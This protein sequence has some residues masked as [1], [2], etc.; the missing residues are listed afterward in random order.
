VSARTVTSPQQRLLRPSKENVMQAQTTAFR[1]A[2]HTSL[3]TRLNA[4]LASVVMSAA[5]LG[6]VALAFERQA[7]ATAP[8]AQAS[9]THAA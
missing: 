3:S 2:L 5:L 4:A 6:G 9:T 7:A 1:P 8:T